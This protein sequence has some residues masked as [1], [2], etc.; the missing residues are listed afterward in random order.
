[1]ALK[2]E[3]KDKRRDNEDYW[4]WQIYL[5]GDQKE[6]SEIE[7]VEYTLHDTFPNPIRR[8]YNLTNGFK[9]KTAGWGIFAIFIRIHF[10]DEKRKDELRTHEFE[11]KDL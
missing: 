1:M 6:L 11:F 7:Y 9:M 3:T 8:V 4:D 10:K 5:T 2:F